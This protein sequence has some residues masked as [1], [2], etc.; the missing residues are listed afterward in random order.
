MIFFLI[1]MLVGIINPV[2]AQP[3]DSSL[4]ATTV[5]I[6]GGEGGIGFDDMTFSSSLHKVLVPAGHTGKLYLI[7]PVTYAMT[8]I[9]GFSSSAANQ[10]G[11]DIGITSADEGEGYL[12]VLD[13]G[14]H[15]L[16]VVDPKSSNQVGAAPLAGD[17]DYV[18]YVGV[19]HEL[20]VTEPH[21]KQLEIFRFSAGAHPAL[22][23]VALISV[24]GG[25]ESL[26]VDHIL[27]RAYTNLG[28]QAAAIDLRSH[29]IVSVWANECE[30]SR[31]NAIDEQ[32]G[33]LFVSC[34][35][36]KALVFDLKQNNKKISEL[37]TDPGADMISYNPKLSHL[38]FTSG[39]NATLSVLGV[40][41]QGKISLL[42]KAQA[43]K[44]AHCVVGDDQNNIWVCDPP[45][46][47]L[48]RYKDAF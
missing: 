10:K 40:S 8:S 46:G 20:W 28:P 25:P 31:G 38:Y 29:V 19:N 1:L 41:A 7:D 35:E 39:K 30:K 17:S 14:R 32:K 47:R 26:V 3:S 4:K 23:P 18:R 22:K 15:E 44:R 16:A 5:A 24:S 27:G 45:G 12:F 13:H 43:D 21:N 37:M 34:A 48:L 36:G 2:F 11:H 42:G 6:P 9:G 33:F